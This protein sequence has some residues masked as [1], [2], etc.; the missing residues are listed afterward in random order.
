V[1]EVERGPVP[2]P[3]ARAVAGRVVA[4]FLM[5][6]GVRRAR[7]GLGREGPAALAADLSDVS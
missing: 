2:L 7:R 3:Q 1:I 6:V 4:I 5:V